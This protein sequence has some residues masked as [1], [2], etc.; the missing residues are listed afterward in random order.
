MTST[1]QQVGK[2]HQVNGPDPRGRF[3]VSE[4]FF[5]KVWGSLT[6]HSRDTTVEPCSPSGLRGSSRIGREGDRSGKSIASD[7]LGGPS[8]GLTY[9]EL[10]L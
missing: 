5:G 3:I 7:S 1:R 6:N 9:L 10:S 8:A 4:A 2:L